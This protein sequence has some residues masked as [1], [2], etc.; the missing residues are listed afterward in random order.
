MARFKKR[1]KKR[2]RFGFLKAKRR[3]SRGGSV[4]LV[5]IDSMAYGAIRAPVS[6]LIQKYIPIPVIGQ[7][8]DELV[9]GGVD[10]LIAKNTSGMIRDIALKGLVI[11]NARAGEAVAQ[12]VL[13]NTT[14]GDV[15]TNSQSW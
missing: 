11:E 7:I 9:M 5:Q 3:G 2:S 6:N 13:G 14:S 1:A 12:M 8:G 15:S 10:Y 4:Q